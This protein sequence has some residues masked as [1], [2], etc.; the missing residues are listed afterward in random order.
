MNFLPG[1]VAVTCLPSHVSVLGRVI[2]SSMAASGTKIWARRMSDY[3]F[4]AEHEQKTSRAIPV[5]VLERRA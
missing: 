2:G 3:S 4:I 5:I 1:G